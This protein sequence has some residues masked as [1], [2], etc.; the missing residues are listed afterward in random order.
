MPARLVEIFVPETVAGEVKHI[1]DER[2][3]ERTI[4]AANGDKTF[5]KV[6]IQADELE[7]LTDLIEPI[8]A[9]AAGSRL[10]VIPVEATSP[11]PEKPERDKDKSK[12]KDDENSTPRHTGRLSREEIHHDV[13]EL[14][15][16]TRVF[17]VLTI[18][19]SVVAAVGFARNS[20]AIIIGAMVIAPLLGPNMALTLATALGDTKLA[21][22]ALKTNLAGVMTASLV[23]ILCG[24]ILPL[25]IGANE[26]AARTS[27][28]T[29]EI[30]L[31]LASGAAGA[32]AVTAGVSASLVGVMVAVALLPPLIIAC[33]LLV[34]GSATDAARAFLL[35]CTNVI[36][37]NLAGVVVFYLKGIK[38]RTWW[39]EKKAKRATAIAFITWIILLA[40][41]AGIIAWTRPW[42]DPAI[43]TLP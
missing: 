34:Q 11:R 30:L 18:L 16:T 21:W 41:V 6:F 31:A 28:S 19:S 20:P 10:I 13:S 38:P 32:I 3:I 42:A 37:V 40:I 27:V 15:D 33:M 4:Y 9:R 17:I 22:R 23:G 24:L 25:E 39:E 35:V 29:G 43:T 36:C 12:D 2:N 1:L 14:A 26:V 7:A 8:L 5:F